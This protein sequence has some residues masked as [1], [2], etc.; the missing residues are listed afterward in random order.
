MESL[1]KQIEMQDKFN[2]Q[3]KL[4]DLET[5]KKAIENEITKI[6]RILYGTDTEPE[7]GAGRR[8]R[9]SNGQNN[10]SGISGD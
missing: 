9:K 10:T 8:T 5:Q 4:A 6:K 1:N 2:W 3:M 7:P